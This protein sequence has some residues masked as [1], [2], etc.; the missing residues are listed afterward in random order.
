MAS[1]YALETYHFLTNFLVGCCYFIAVYGIG[2]SILHSLPYSFPRILRPAIKAITGF[3]TVSL[4]IQLLA[5]FFL[6]NAVSLGILMP[7]LAVS[8][9]WQLYK[10]TRTD[11]PS[12]KLFLTIS[13]QNRGWICFFLL[14]F[15]PIAVYACLPST[16]IDELF[17]HQLVAQRIVMDGGMVFYR[18][19]WEAAM[20]P[21][22]I[23]N[24]S[25]VPLV[26]GR[27]PDAA[28]VVS[29]CLFS[30]FLWTVYSIFTQ[31][32]IS[33]FKKWIIL[34]ISCLGLYRLT[35]TTAGSHHFGDLAAFMSLYLVVMMRSLKQQSSIQAI[36]LIQGILMAAIAGSK[37]SLLPYAILIGIYTLYEA[38]RQSNLKTKD[39]ILLVGPV[40][41]FYLPIVVWTY[42][43]TH[44]PF[45]LILSQYFDTKLIDKHLLA[46]TL[47]HETVVTPTF[48]VHGREALLHFPFFLVLSP[49]LFA[50]S[51]HSKATKVKVLSFFF[52]YS[53]ILYSFHLLYHPR[54]WGNLPLSLLILSVIAP[55]KLLSS[56]FPSVF[57]KMLLLLAVFSVAV[58]PYVALS[59][60]YLYHLL[61]FPLNETTKTSFYRKFIPL[62][63]D[64]KA[65]DKLL[66][67]DACLYT[68]NR[69]NLVHA[70]RSIF[71]D[72]L[73]ICNCASVYA[74]QCDTLL[75]PAFIST[76]DKKYRLGKLVYQN[77]QA[78]ITIY[79]TPN[80]LPKTGKL[81]VYQLNPF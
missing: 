68:Q 78:K 12:L 33:S 29:L 81:S 73:D 17:Y 34:S 39:L 6:V 47:Q 3:L 7:A 61:P 55:P 66:P 1:Y 62:Y 48:G 45:G 9:L 44:S 11:W 74:F 18:Q 53:F 54:F 60:Y 67:A 41:V 16:K 63:D 59:Y 50:L 20:P 22:L 80:K 49:I 72:S 37:M 76:R 69:L 8:T 10:L 51:A 56:N 13:T 4:L 40:L 23:Y 70:P 64:Y 25:Q 58:L 26:Y 79:R 19:P 30:L 57:G 65:L 75:L 38:G 21:H 43:Q 71:R 27:F 52:L 14:C 32:P 24:F 5:F 15:L 42:A 28:N 31:A 77:R 46:A 36:L 2:D 35:F